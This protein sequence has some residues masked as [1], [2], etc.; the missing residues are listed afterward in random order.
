MSLGDAW[1]LSSVVTMM[2]LG[3]ARYFAQCINDYLLSE[4]SL[5]SL[6]CLT[7][8]SFSSTERLSLWLCPS[9]LVYVET[10]AHLS[11]DA[12]NEVPGP[13]VGPSTTLP[14]VL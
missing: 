5:P 7:T 4:P 14:P 9:A 2:S 11:P 13:H 1:V 10:S 8:C 6:S 3:S 12:T